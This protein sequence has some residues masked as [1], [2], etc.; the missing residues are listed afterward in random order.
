MSK[1][2][3]NSKETLGKGIRSL[4]QDIHQDINTK[5]STFEVSSIESSISFVNLP[6]E[7]IQINPKQPRKDFDEGAL[8][9]LAESIKIHSIIQ[10]ITVVRKDANTFVLISGERRLRASKLAGLKEIPAY[11]RKANDQELL[12]LSLLE[13]LQRENLNAIEIGISFKRLMDECKFTQEQVADRMSKERS[14][15]ANYIRLLKLP[16]AIQNAVRENKLSMGHARCLI[17]LEQIDKQLFAFKEIETKSLSVRKTEQLVKDLMAENISLKKATQNNQEN[18][19]LPHA[20]KKVEDALA[21]HYCTKVSIAHSPKSNKGKIL[22]EY[23]SIEEFNAIMDKM[24]IS[25][26]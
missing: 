9:E 7:K 6:L 19:K 3:S 13:N 18:T 14:T 8:K 20:F 22:L 15:V 24:G 1:S 4:L 12:E 16:P 10:P 25:I 21:S 26:S 23:Y 17:T 5:N 11:I 2:K